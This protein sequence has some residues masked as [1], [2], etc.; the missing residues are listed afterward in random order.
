MRTRR[1]L[2]HASVLLASLIGSVAPAGAVEF[3]VVGSRAAGMGGTGV[4]ST[5]DAFATY[6]NPAGLAMS[7]SVDI[8]GQVTAQVTDRLGVVDTLDQIN[9]IS[10]TDISAG[11][12]ARLQGLLNRL[13]APG[14]NV[15]AVGDAGVYAK[16]NI[17]GHAFGISIADVAT[18]G[19]FTATP[20]TAAV[21]GS[22][23][24]VTGNMTGK[25]LEARQLTFSYATSFLDGAL[26]IGATGKAI[27]G[28]AYNA[29]VQVLDA[30]ADSGIKDNIGKA[31]IS[32]K[33]GL[34]L[35][36]IYRPT[37]WARAGIVA[38]DINEP[39]FD[40]PNG[41]RYKLGTQIR[42]GLALN[43]W[44]TMT[45][46]IDGD[47]TSNKTLIPGQKSRVIG[48]GLEQTLLAETISIRAGASKNT[49]DAAS[50]VMPTAGLGLK[51]WILRMDLGGGYD[52]RERQAM[53][54]GTVGF[55]F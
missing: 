44:E 43:P 37:A 38:K 36:A 14:A 25:A 11:N 4:A 15:S 7:R 20:L 31:K 13:S 30:A 52:F 49:E 23:L 12:Q 19:L 10:K 45:I 40:A 39:A 21:S 22:Q 32:T 53:A 9:G 1:L 33:L 42:G 41:E 27:Q 54:S 55:T 17:G 16:F 28:A 24:T 50:K 6:W 48:L 35:G 8:R 47:I 51:L 5:S 3:A 18:G 26:A 29:S 2:L 34:D 46:S